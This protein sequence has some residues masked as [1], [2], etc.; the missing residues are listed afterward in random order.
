MTTWAD[1][2]HE[3]PAFAEYVRGRFEQHG[4]ALLATLREDGA[5]RISG[6]EPILTDGNLWLGMM[7]GSV[8]GG[9]LRRD[10][11][12]AL[13]SATIDKDVSDGD[14]KI[15]GTATRVDARDDPDAPDIG[16]EADLFR[17]D[18][19]EVASVRV[20]GDH[21]VIES[22]RPGEGVVTRRRT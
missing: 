21:L 16:R 4:V 18:L 6:L 20:G 11:R 19:A 2:R 15:S 3:A 8:K 7:P 14:V 5:P 13:H 12:F 10:G 1:F 22:W 9:D 17:A